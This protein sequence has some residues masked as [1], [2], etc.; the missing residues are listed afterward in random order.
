MTGYVP[1]YNLY[2]VGT[3]FAIDDISRK[4]LCVISS[5]L[6]ELLRCPSK[7]VPEVC[8]KK[9]GQS[10]L[11]VGP[12]WYSQSRWVKAYSIFTPLIHLQI[13]LES[14]RIPGASSGKGYVKPR[15]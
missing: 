14:T 8:T 5:S 3:K 15:T 7:M 2:D 1:T 13:H 6:L 9:E 11:V 10:S 12:V 4:V